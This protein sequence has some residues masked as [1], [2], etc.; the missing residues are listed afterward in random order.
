MFDIDA[1]QQW[2][3]LIFLELYNVV[4]RDVVTARS[5]FT[6]AHNTDNMCK[7]S[8]THSP[9]HDTE[10]TL[11]QVRQ[12]GGVRLSCHRNRALCLLLGFWF[13]SAHFKT[14]ACPGLILQGGQPSSLQRR[15]PS[16]SARLLLR[17]TAL[18]AATSRPLSSRASP[19]VQTHRV[20][21]CSFG[22][23]PPVLVTVADHR[24]RF[25]SFQGVLSVRGWSRPR[26][27]QRAG[28]A[29]SPL[30]QRAWRLRTSHRPGHSAAPAP[31]GPAAEKVGLVFLML[32]FLELGS[33]T[34]ATVFERLSGI[35]LQQQLQT[36]CGTV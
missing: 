34:A 27:I 4:T 14:A 23:P 19:A 2:G 17:Q 12:C 35:W 31:P 32:L 36:V 22:F 1:L 10:I 6:A 5:I 15:P 7:Q 30:H 8:H 21:R 20:T 11:T 28:A 13:D 33:A 3:P 16:L 29:L 25:C 26:R 9:H 24:G 18:T